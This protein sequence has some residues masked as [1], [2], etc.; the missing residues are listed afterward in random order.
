MF[1]PSRWSISWE[2]NRTFW[3]MCDFYKAPCGCH[4]LV[5]GPIWVEVLGDYCYEYAK[6]EKERKKKRSKKS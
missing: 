1:E 3:K 2:K 5:L 4:F 6:A